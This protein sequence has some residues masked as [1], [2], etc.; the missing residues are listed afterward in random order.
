MQKNKELK[1]R[2]QSQSKVNLVD[3][4]DL[5]QEAEEKVLTYDMKYR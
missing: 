5:T 2:S 3:E 4:P 1:K